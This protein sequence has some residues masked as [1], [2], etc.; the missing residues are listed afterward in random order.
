MV[1]EPV[2]DKRFG[3]S[4]VGQ[5]RLAHDPRVGSPDEIRPTSR[6]EWAGPRGEMHEEVGL[7]GVLM[8]EYRRRGY[9]C[10]QKDEE[11]GKHH[12]VGFWKVS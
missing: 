10:H 8:S 12:G 6:L 11:T 2:E 9:Q 3:R 1:R 5:E 7:R 4:A